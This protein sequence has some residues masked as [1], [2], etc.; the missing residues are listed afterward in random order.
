M[1]DLQV[2]SF[3]IDQA[4]LDEEARLETSKFLLSPEDTDHSVDPETQARLEALLEAAGEGKHFIF[5]YR[6]NENNSKL[7][8]MNQ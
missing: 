7:C 5:V 3:V 6:I 8:D 4:E 1:F 2:E